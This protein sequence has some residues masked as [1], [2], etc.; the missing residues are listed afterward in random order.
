MISAIYA[1]NTASAIK[2]G[3]GSIAI[4]EFYL[5]TASF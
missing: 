5:P 2:K 3:H 4:L 1:Q